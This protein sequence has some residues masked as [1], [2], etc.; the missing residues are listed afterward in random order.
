M[1]FKL[2]F[3]PCR[4]L[5]IMWILLKYMLLQLT[6]DWHSLLNIPTLGEPVSS[7]YNLETC[8]YPGSRCFLLLLYVYM[9]LLT[10]SQLNKKAEWCF[11]ISVTTIVSSILIK[12]LPFCQFDKLKE[13]FHVLRCDC[14]PTELIH[15]SFFSS[16]RPISLGMVTTSKGVFY[17]WD[18]RTC[19]TSTSRYEF[20]SRPHRRPVSS[21]SGLFLSVVLLFVNLNW[22][23][24]HVVVRNGGK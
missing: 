11:L 9:Y 12:T 24:A 13:H 7:L 19:F 16:I 6:M 3:S 14:T 22:K 8:K 2:F 23:Y 17:G 1:L 20:C 18:I 4:E 21:F 15:K 5:G 10:F